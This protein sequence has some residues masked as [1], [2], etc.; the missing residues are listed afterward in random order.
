MGA[1]IE[2]LKSITL[3][4]A[5]AVLL[6]WFGS[7]EPFVPALTEPELERCPGPFAD[8]TTFTVALAA[9]A[10]VLREQVNVGGV[11]LGVVQVPGDALA[12]T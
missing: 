11:P 4:L 5:L 12:E 1:V 7:A 8:S 6:L 10:N 3:T 2:R 9:E